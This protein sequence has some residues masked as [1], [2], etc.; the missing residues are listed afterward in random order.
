M[1]NR[2]YLETIRER[3]KKSKVYADFQ[4]MGLL[5]A[6]ALRDTKHTSLYIKLA[7]NAV[8][9]RKLLEIARQIE[10][11]KRVENRGAYF[12]R[13]MEKEGL[14]K[15]TNKEKPLKNKLKKYGGRKK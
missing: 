14:L 1:I 11:N 10:D 9:K 2:D 8:N 3:A 13:I 5:I 12:M 7:K 15:E 4:M 6:Q